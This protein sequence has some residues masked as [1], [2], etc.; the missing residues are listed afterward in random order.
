MLFACRLSPPISF[1]ENQKWLAFIFDVSHERGTRRTARAGAGRASDTQGHDH[2][3]D[4]NLILDPSQFV[5]PA[6]GL[7]RARYRRKEFAL[8]Q[9]LFHVGIVL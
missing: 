2:G 1:Y 9:I 4:L 3:R 5:E 8:V 6:R 7:A